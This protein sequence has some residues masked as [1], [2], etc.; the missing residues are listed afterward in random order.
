MTGQSVLS[1]RLSFQAV[2]HAG[3]TDETKVVLLKPGIWRRYEQD[4]CVSWFAKHVHKSMTLRRKIYH[5]GRCGCVTW[6]DYRHRS[7]LTKD[8]WPCC[9]IQVN[10]G[11]RQDYYDP[12][13]ERIYREKKKY[14]VWLK[15]T[16][17]MTVLI[18]VRDFP[19]MIKSNRNRRTKWTRERS[20]QKNIQELAFA[21]VPYA[22]KV[23]QRRITCDTMLWSTRTRGNLGGIGRN[24]VVEYR[25]RLTNAN[26][27]ERRNQENH[28][29]FAGSGGHNKYENLFWT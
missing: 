1:E 14:A 2:D 27:T 24:A 4:I 26:H 16:L 7:G 12:K 3:L 8:S 10:T 17:T 13:V 19:M 25:E 20:Y 29:T 28:W 11:K 22:C 6:Q 9:W 15:L 23:D 21:S 5:C 18:G